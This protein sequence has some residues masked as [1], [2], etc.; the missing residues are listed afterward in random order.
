MLL[1]RS[2]PTRELARRV[3]DVIEAG[4]LSIFPLD[5]A[6]AIFGVERDAIENIFKAKQ[7]DSSRQNGML[8][9][10]QLSE[11]IHRLPDTSRHIIRAL[12]EEYDL[13][14]SVVAPFKADHSIFKEVDPLVMKRCTRNGTLD[15]LMNSGP[16]HAE[17]ASDS[18]ARGVPLFGSSA[19]I[20]LTGSR[21]RLEDVDDDVRGVAD[22]EID[23]GLV[24]FSN[25][26]GR[27]STI[28][29]FVDYSILRPGVCAPQ[30]TDIFARRFN[31]ALRS[32]AL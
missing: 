19:N 8:G 4:G 6:Y 29:D 9:N 26:A 13:P 30:L 1:T 7:R 2:T 3:V 24:K 20:S 5:V 22:L 16:L 12:V 14:F 10:L 11:S 17:L 23:G 27:S 31:I 32:P 28:I 15:M 21:Y 18:S 25:D